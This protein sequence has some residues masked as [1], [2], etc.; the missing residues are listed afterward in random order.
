MPMLIQVTLESSI[1]LKY[2]PQTCRGIHEHIASEKKNKENERRVQVE[3]C[4]VVTA[5]L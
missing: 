2:W 3:T 4:W 5:V 1:T